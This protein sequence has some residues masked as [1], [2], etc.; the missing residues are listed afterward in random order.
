MKNK[1]KNAVKS[2]LLKLFRIAF[3]FLN[4]HPRLHGKVLYYSHKWGL[5]KNIK[6]FYYRSILKLKEEYSDQMF[7]PV[8]VDIPSSE[9]TPLAKEIYLQLKSQSSNK[10]TEH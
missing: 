7:G 2:S 9:L 6:K 8:I 3:N 5:H 4:Q 10:V 1:L